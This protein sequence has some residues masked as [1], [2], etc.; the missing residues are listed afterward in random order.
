MARVGR[1]KGYPNP[2]KGKYMK[3]KYP[4][5]YMDI[6]DSRIVASP[7]YSTLADCA[8]S[9]TRIHGTKFSIKTLHLEY[10]IRFRITRIK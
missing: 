7:N 5:R 6:G 1:P 4:W 10:G 8:L 3:S 2:N 9:Q